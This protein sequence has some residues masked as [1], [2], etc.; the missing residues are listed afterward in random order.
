MPFVVFLVTFHLFRGMTLTL[1]A[2]VIYWMKP[3]EVY[4]IIIQ[5]TPVFQLPQVNILKI[6]PVENSHC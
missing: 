2:S 5:R 3:R 4:L 1:V 6:L